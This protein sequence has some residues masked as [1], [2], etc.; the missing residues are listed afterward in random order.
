MYRRISALLIGL[1]GI[2]LAY[3]GEASTAES[4]NA[5]LRPDVMQAAYN[6]N[7][8]DAQ[9][10]RFASELRGFVEGYQQSVDKVLNRGDVSDPAGRIERKRNSLAKKMD[11]SMSDILNEAQMP[12]YRS[13]RDLLLAEL[14][15]DVDAYF[16][17]PDEAVIRVGTVGSH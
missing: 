7:M 11:R 15:Q 14:D 9:R 5:W 3:G 8:T 12:A 13:Y 10:A 4:P 2:H 17:K 1:F 16:Q 6:I